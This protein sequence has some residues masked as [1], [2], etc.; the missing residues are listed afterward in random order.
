V[1]FED[2]IR[3]KQQAARA[4]AVQGKQDRAAALKQWKAAIDA[5]VPE[6]ARA[7]K[8]VGVKSYPNRSLMGFGPKQWIFELGNK[9]LPHITV[10]ATGSWHFGVAGAKPS[11]DTQ[12]ELWNDELRNLPNCLRKQVEEQALRNR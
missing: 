11:K 2:D 9:Y 3:A 4:G 7:C 10:T 6:I 1:G 5:A 8:N 12:W